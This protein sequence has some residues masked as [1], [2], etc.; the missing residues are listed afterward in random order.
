VRQKVASNRNRKLAAFF[1]GNQSFRGFADL[2][3]C[4]PFYVNVQDAIGVGLYFLA[5]K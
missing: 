1:M 4:G 3:A 2:F 5:F